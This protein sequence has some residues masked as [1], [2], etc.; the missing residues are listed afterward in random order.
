MGFAFFTAGHL[1]GKGECERREE[2]EDKYERRE[3][4]E[5]NHILEDCKEWN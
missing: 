3:E 2:N 1:R 5:E 4:N